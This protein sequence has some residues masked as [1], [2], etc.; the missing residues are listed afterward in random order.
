MP[1]GGGPEGPSRRHR[2][3]GI[4]ASR[5]GAPLWRAG[6]HLTVPTIPKLSEA[7]NVRR[8]FFEKADFEAVVEAL[9]DELKDVAILAISRVGGGARSSTHLGGRGP[10]GGRDHAPGRSVEEPE[11]EDSPARCE[12]TALVERRWAARNDSAARWDLRVTD[13]VFH[14]AGARWSTSVRHGDQRAGPRVSRKALPRSEAN[15][16]QEHGEGW[17]VAIGRPGNQRSPDLRRVQALRH[18]ESGRQAAGLQARQAYEATL[19]AK[20]S[21]IAFRSARPRGCSVKI[22]DTFRI[23]EA[24]RVL[25]ADARSPRDLNDLGGFGWLR[26]LDLN[27]RPLGYEP[28]ELPDCS[29]PR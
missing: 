6:V 27:Q 7:H 25:T 1:R 4:A 20:S 24:F 9:P 11:A 23:P 22:S 16:G 12:L 21:V 29:T 28:N 3:S 8:R 18:H 14:R 17:R 19:P 13:L 15:G 5:A 10:A 2:Q 26:G